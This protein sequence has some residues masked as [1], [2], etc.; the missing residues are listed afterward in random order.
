M[1]HNG[2]APMILYTELNRHYLN[3]IGMV[4]LAG[5]WLFITSGMIAFAEDLGLSLELEPSTEG[6]WRVLYTLSEPVGSLVFARGNGDYRSAG[7]GYARKRCCRGIDPGVVHNVRYSDDHIRCD[8]ALEYAQ[9]FG[10]TCRNTAWVFRNQPRPAGAGHNYRLAFRLFHRR[11]LGLWN[12]S[13]HRCT[14]DGCVGISRD[15]SRHA[16][17]DGGQ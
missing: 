1:A 13:R 4:I 14:A 8:F 7:L 2:R 6:N 12:T 3:R 5:A 9:V 10:R 11:R 16:W 15:G 17:D